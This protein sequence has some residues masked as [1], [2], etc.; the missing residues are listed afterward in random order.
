[1]RVIEESFDSGRKHPALPPLRWLSHEC[2]VFRHGTCERIVGLKIRRAGSTDSINDRAVKLLAR[3]VKTCNHRLGHHCL[4][5]VS[6]VPQ[7]AT[8]D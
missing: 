4:G 3:Q 2:N 6:F 5:L 7:G 1:M 8:N